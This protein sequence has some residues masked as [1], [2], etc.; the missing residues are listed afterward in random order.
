MTKSIYILEVKETKR[1]REMRRLK[2]RVKDALNDGS[3]YTG[4]CGAF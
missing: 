3:E 1:R 4:G 2:D